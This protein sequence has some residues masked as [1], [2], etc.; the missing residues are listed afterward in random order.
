[1]IRLPF[2][3]RGIPAALLLVAVVAVAG[4]SSDSSQ[5]SSGTGSG[6]SGGFDAASIGISTLPELYKGNESAPPADAPKP[7]AGKSIYWISCGQ[8]AP[9]C[10]AKAVE[11]QKASEAMG[12]DFHLIDGNFGVAGA[13]ANAIR[14]AIAA[15]ADAIVEDAFPCSDVQQPLEEA[16]AAGIPVLGMDTIDCSDAGGPSLFTAEMKYNATE[17]SATD[18]WRGFGKYSAQYLINATGGQAKI[19]NSPG[20]NSQQQ[21]LNDGFLAEIKK[22]SGCEVV[23]TLKWNTADFVPNGPWTSAFRSSLVKHPEATAV[24]V[25]FDGMAASLGGSQAI[26]DAGKKICTGAPPYGSDC[27]TAVGGLGTSETLDLVRGGQW[28]GDGSAYDSGWVAWGAV[29]ELNRVFND[30][31]TVPEGI[32]FT[33]VDSQENLPAKSGESFTTSFDFRSAYLKAWGVS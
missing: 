32:G 2:H 26:R 5:G 24:Y 10:A 20:T 31:P 1:M 11:G 27:V 9:N 25:P 29:D 6:S 30:Q 15:K 33:T 13:Y 16:K 12:W 7:V 23:D 19:I 17:Q 3:R 8:Q 21:L 4:C 14:T 28:T 18:Y 22:C